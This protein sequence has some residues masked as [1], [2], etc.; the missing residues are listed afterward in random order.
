MVSHPN[1]D[2]LSPV[3]DESLIG[4][5]LNGRY[6]LERILGE[7]G[8]G[9]V[10]LA[11]HTRLGN[12]VA[13][14]VLNQECSANRD[15]RRRFER[16]ARALSG[17]SHPHIVAITDFSISEG[18]TYL[19]ME[20]LEG[21][22][23][24]DLLRSDEALPAE[25]ALS[26]GRQILRGL[27]FAHMR[28]VLHR[29]LKPANV[30]LQSFP[31]CDMHVKLLDFGLAKIMVANT[32]GL[33]NEPT[34]TRN[35]VILGTPA[36]MA[37]EQASGAKV[38]LRADVY[39]AGVLL[40]ELISGRCPF[41]AP[42]YVDVIH[43]HMFDP[44]PRLSEIQPRLVATA[45]LDAL[46][47]RAMAK[48]PEDRYADA[49]EMLKAVAELPRP[50]VS[51]LPANTSHLRL[52]GRPHPSGDTTAISPGDRP[53]QAHGRQPT[54]TAPV[55]PRDLSTPMPFS[56]R[57]ARRRGGSG[58]LLVVLACAVLGAG[59][60]AAW[61]MLRQRSPAETPLAATA[62]QSGGATP[63]RAA[64]TVA[65]AP[66][67]RPLGPPQA[68]STSPSRAAPAA[69][70]TDG[71][72]EPGSAIAWDT[73]AGPTPARLAPLV[74]QVRNGKRLGRGDRRKLRSLQKRRDKD[75]RPLLWLAHDS[76]L[77]KDWATALE[78]YAAA[79]QLEPQC[80]DDGAMLGDL[81][82]TMNSARLA[83]R[84]SAL[85][86]HH[87]GAKAL[88]Q[89]HAALS[90]PNASAATKMRFQKLVGQLSKP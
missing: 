52:S 46:I 18:I 36:Y 87:Y 42:N 90:D 20:F 67:Q 15:V 54:P 74:E 8:V 29:D 37:P 16:E 17:L 26:I 59:G 72:A 45:E 81:V 41:I 9:V 68:N 51:Y 57:R 50:A 61:W 38:D 69:T 60:A 86:A 1:E 28:G 23:L 21:R 4:R 88:P 56:R 66:Q 44:V 85:I 78:E 63:G 53:L 30:F 32:P 5:V 13:V 7:G 12:P 73:Y 71:A 76:M 65:A 89:L 24:A 10:Y 40:F 35:G 77:A 43:A 58:L 39:S 34:L 80:R 75:P 83:E 6:R 3:V 31:D 48:A 27:A 25:L 79:L 11:Q 62:G 70:T 47:A 64:A 22:T 2:I 49:S 55:L 19:A 33:K 14:K 84:A 82:R